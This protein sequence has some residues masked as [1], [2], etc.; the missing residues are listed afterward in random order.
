MDRGAWRATVHGV[1][2]SWTRWSDLA[3]PSCLR[4]RKPVLHT[5]NTQVFLESLLCIVLQVD[6]AME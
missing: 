5:P 6:V 1:A 4:M 3:C 2:K